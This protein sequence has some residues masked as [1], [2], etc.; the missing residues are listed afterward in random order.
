MKALIIVAFLETVAGC[1]S[2]CNQPETNLERIECKEYF[3]DLYTTC[4]INCSTDDITCLSA[5]SRE[6]DENLLK[7]GFRFLVS[8]SVSLKKP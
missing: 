3:N 7:R 2:D 6:L 8:Q 5:V 4:S 1:S